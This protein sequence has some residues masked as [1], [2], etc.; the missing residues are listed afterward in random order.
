MKKYLRYLLYVLGILVVL[1]I[2]LFAY[3]YYNKAQLLKSITTAMSETLRAKVTAEDLKA[4]FFNDFPR[5]SLSL[6]N[7]EVHDSLY[8]IYHTPLISAEKVYLKTDI[9]ELLFMRININSFKIKNASFTIFKTPSGYSNDYIFRNIDSD[10]VKK[11]KGKGSVKL[12]IEE[13]IFENVKVVMNDS[14]KVKRFAIDFQKL[15]NHLDRTDSIVNINMA[16]QLHFGG[17]GFNLRK[18]MYL[19]NK[20]ATVNFHL[21]IVKGSQTLQILP[22]SELVIDKSQFKLAG[23]LFT[24]KN[25][26]LQLNFKN[27]GVSFQLA[28][29]VVTKKIAGKLAKF[30][31]TSALQTDFTLKT[32]LDTTGLD[33]EIDIH[34]TSSR[35]IAVTIGG[36]VIDHVKFDGYFTNHTDSGKEAGD[37]NSQ[38][39]FKDLSASIEGFPFKGTLVVNNFETTR[40]NL[41]VI[42]SCRLNEQKDMVDQNLL[43]LKSG[44]LDLQLHYSGPVDTLYYSESKKLIGSLNGKLNIENGEFIYLPKKFKFLKLNVHCTFNE[45][46]FTIHKLTGQI[47]RSSFNATGNVSQ[48][49]PFLIAPDANTVAQLDFR[50][51]GIY[52]DDF[53]QPSTK[54]ATKKTSSKKAK[55]SVSKKIDEIINNINLDAHLSADVINFKKFTGKNAHAKCMITFTGVTL[56]DFSMENSGGMYSLDVAFNKQSNNNYKLNAKVE[57]SNADAEQLFLSCSNFGQDKITDKNIKGTISLKAD[58]TCSLNNALQVVPETMDGTV[59]YTIKNGQLNHLK[60]LNDI[61]KFVFRDRDFDNITFQDIISKVDING[62]DIDIGQLDIA[63]NVLS[64]RVNGIYSF[65]NNTDMS[66]QIP[67]K[68]FERSDKQ[69]NITLEDLYNYKGANVFLRAKSK[70]NGKVAITYDPLKKFRKPKK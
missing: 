9:T 57:V 25:S 17:L 36:I 1:S 3:V 43:D 4:T 55:L 8:N 53:M 52:L 6:I 19:E 21:K 7:T 27:A 24:G 46:D 48:L 10:T 62:P 28:S 29:T 26:Y 38:I 60:V 33:P 39:R 31:W 12:N 35:G 15:S 65:K 68:N 23:K 64:M 56:T 63:S 66:I 49:I 34:A 61:T 45:S 11:E 20:N 59:S 37:P 5:I 42:S 32:R 41:D 40:I 44:K 16:G 2:S 70:E 58:Y 67:L 18:G 13:I 54:S 50:S 47:N 14:L 22:Q 30:K 51:D 69:Y